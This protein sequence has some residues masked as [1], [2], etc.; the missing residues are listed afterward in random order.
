MT[1]YILTDDQRRR[2][3]E[4]RDTLLQVGIDA[5]IEALRISRVLVDQA[6]QYSCP[7]N[8][9]L[10]TLRDIRNGWDVT[11]PQCKATWTRLDS[12]ALRDRPAP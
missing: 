7:H 4:A 8:P 12:T 3:I 5:D 9:E 11:C 1:S 6:L 10:H 2:I